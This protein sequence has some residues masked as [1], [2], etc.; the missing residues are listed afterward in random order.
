[1]HSQR[2]YLGKHQGKLHTHVPTQDQQA[3]TVHEESLN[4]RWEATIGTITLAAGQAS[5]Q[6]TCDW[7][8]L[9]A[10]THSPASFFFTENTVSSISVLA[11]TLVA[12]L[13]YASSADWNL[14]YSL[15]KVQG[16]SCGE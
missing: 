4:R 12:R 9:R 13:Q 10:L 11:S 6:L 7:S 16:A 2:W 14:L 5:Q 1:M 3:T 15:S 8:T